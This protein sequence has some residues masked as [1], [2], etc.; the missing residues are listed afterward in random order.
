MR[1]WSGVAVALVQL[2]VQAGTVLGT[3][4]QFPLGL[5]ADPPAPNSAKDYCPQFSPL[6]P[7]AHHGI[8]K[9]LEDE[10]NTDDFLLQV[11]DTLG[12]VVRVP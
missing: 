1:H 7:K 11:V 9:A 12:A 2:S 6:Y 4:Y 3:P 8:D 10:Y 5:P